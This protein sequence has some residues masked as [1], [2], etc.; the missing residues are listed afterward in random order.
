M[1]SVLLCRL[2][3]LFGVLLC[4]LKTGAVRALYMRFESLQ[5]AVLYCVGWWS[6]MHSES[7]VLPYFEF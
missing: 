3:L 1:C 5:C 7:D 4:R 2:N 6:C